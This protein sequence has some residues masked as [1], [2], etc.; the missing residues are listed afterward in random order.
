MSF[1]RKNIR[2]ATA[3]VVRAAELGVSSNELVKQALAFLAQS[4]GADRFGV[5]LRSSE[6]GRPTIFRDVL[7]G[8]TIGRGPEALPEHW[9]QLSPERLPAIQRLSEGRTVEE[10]LLGKTPLR[11]LDPFMRFRSLL[12]VPVLQSGL[13][14]GLILAGSRKAAAALPR[15]KMESVAAELSLALALNSEREFSRHRLMDAKLC[16]EI[17]SDLG[18]REYSAGLSRIVDSCTERAGIAGV[19]AQF[20][21][22]AAVSRPADPVASESGFGYA[23]KSGPSAWSEVLESER[24]AALG[25]RALAS[26]RV[27]GLEV[28]PPRTGEKGQSRAIA[29]PLTAGKSAVG[30]L[31]V[32]V[33]APQIS[34]PMLDRLEVRASCASCALA[35]ASGADEA[36]RNAAGDADNPPNEMGREYGS[37]SAV[38]P[39]LAHRERLAALGEM[40][41]A[42]AHELSSPL[43][44]IVGYAHRLLAKQEDPERGEEIRRIL[45]EAERASDILR[46]V[47]LTARETRREHHLIS[48][49]EVVERTVELQR[50]ALAAEKI[51]A[52]LSLGPNLPSLLAD[53]GQLQQVLTN[54]LANAR[55]ALENRQD[56]V[57]RVTTGRGE[58]PDTVRLEI[59]DNG[60]GVPVHL[61]PR[62]FD[63][64]FTTKPAGSGTG[65]GLAI[66]M[67]IVREHGGEV[68][69]SSPPG[70]GATFMVELPASVEGTEAPSEG[71][72]RSAAGLPPDVARGDARRRA[73]QVSTGRSRT[74]RVLVVE[75]EPTVAQLIADVL[76]D[77]GFRVETVLSGRE[78]RRRAAM[79]DFD[80]IVCD[81]KMPDFDGARFYEWLARGKNPR[82]HKFLF[83]TGDVLAFHT[84]EFLERTGTPYV[85]KPFRME[86]LTMKVNQVLAGEEE[87]LETRKRNTAVNATKG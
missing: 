53:P 81:M 34:L 83:V 31:V 46:Q 63:P 82:H 79:E 14:S 73:P 64:F 7:R 44:S 78:A 58:T 32:I 41:S 17:L 55:Q 1:K 51:R 45:T 42:V 49:N 54:L 57:I 67:G 74:R 33:A 27:S 16:R 50:F 59:S 2:I 80:L 61:V 15:E 10:T 18:K 21:A 26:G 87:S 65:L 35:L 60:P 38:R 56:G 3:S 5:W 71:W 19:G 28:L 86:E 11:E 40:A 36:A 76:G 72:R 13:F 52:E 70:G 48:L 8:A 22:I 62:I 37:R 4:G 69:A 29:I 23:W 85:A 24:V 68:R 9:S 84:R 75:D 6:A 43:T 77:E 25:R 12:W 39:G 66:V 47:L 20:A 30:L